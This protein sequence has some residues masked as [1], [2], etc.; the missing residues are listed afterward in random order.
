MQPDTDKWIEAGVSKCLA[1]PITPDLSRDFLIGYTFAQLLWFW[2]Y[3]I[4][5]PWGTMSEK[6]EYIAAMKLIY[7]HAHWV[8]GL[9]FDDELKP[10]IEQLYEALKKYNWEA[11]SA[12]PEVVWAWLIEISGMTR[13]QWEHLPFEI[14]RI[15]EKTIIC[16]IC[17]ADGSLKEIAQTSDWLNPHI[18]GARLNMSCSKC[19]AGLAFDITKNRIQPVSVK[20]TL[21]LMIISLVLLA[22]LLITP[23]IGFFHR[24]F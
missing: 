1:E 16:P 24:V 17:G 2:R 10:V 18:V 3:N 9:E 23:L 8:S 7:E 19:D 21:I 20:W 11:Y 15:L 12:L 5:E 6:W 4:P 22:G 14:N 13:E